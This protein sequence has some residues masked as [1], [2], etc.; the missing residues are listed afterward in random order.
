MCNELAGHDV[1]HRVDSADCAS[2][3][4]ASVNKGARQLLLLSL[5]CLMAQLLCDVDM[6]EERELQVLEAGQY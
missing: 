6:E 2:R 3:C 4:R 5:S 1:A